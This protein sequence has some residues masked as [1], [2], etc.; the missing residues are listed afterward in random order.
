MKDKEN[1]FITLFQSKLIGDDGAIVG[2]NIYSSDLFCED[3]H[4]KLEWMSLKEIAYKAMIINISDAIVMNAKPR[5]AL[6]NVKLPRDFTTDEMDML[7][8]GFKEATKEYE[9]EIIGGDTIA[10]EG[11]DISITIISHSTNPTKRDSINLGDLIGFTGDLGSVGGDLKKLLDGKKIDKNSKFIRPTLRSDFFY[12]ASSHFT[13]AM[14]ISDGLSKDL[15][16]LSTI[17]GVGFEFFKKLDR[18]LLC[19]GEEY[20]VLFSCDE[21]D[22]DTIKKIAKQT[23]TPVTFFAKAIEGSYKTICKE[24]HFE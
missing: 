18:Q 12:K 9:I 7:A 23:D 10:G 6:L 5:Y 21:R 16:R 15:S 14:D 20:E 2:K 11:L 4:F 1:Y 3:I 24:N 17:N 13:S 19:S 22:L 8:D